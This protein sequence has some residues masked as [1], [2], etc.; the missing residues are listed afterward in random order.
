MTSPPEHDP[1]PLPPEPPA[2]NE[3]CG[4]GCPLCVYDLYEDQK[5]QYRQ[6]LAAWL[7]RHPEAAG[8]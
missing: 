8:G 2:D 5:T 1:R 4:S 7:Q 3:C 6:A